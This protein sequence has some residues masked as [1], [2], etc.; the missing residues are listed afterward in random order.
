MKT[1]PFRLQRKELL[2][3]KAISL[4]KEGLTTREVAKIVKKSHT[5]VWLLIREEFPNLYEK[6]VRTKL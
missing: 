1:S 2:K 4:Y 3:Q 5:W 6:N